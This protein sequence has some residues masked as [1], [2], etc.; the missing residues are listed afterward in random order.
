MRYILNKDLKMSSLIQQ[1]AKTLF[2]K[3]KR[4]TLT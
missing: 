2:R 1:Y 3:D 4:R